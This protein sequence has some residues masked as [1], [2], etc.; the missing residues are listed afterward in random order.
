MREMVAGGIPPAT[1]CTTLISGDFNWVA[2][3]GD[4]THHGF[5]PDGPHPDEAEEERWLKLLANHGPGFEWCQ[6]NL[7]HKSGP[8][9]ARLDRVY[10]NHP[11]A[12]Q[13]DR[14][15]TC[16]T[17]EWTELSAHRA[18]TFSRSS[19]DS[20]GKAIQAGVGKDIAW[21]FHTKLRYLELTRGY[22]QVGHRQAQQ[23]QKGHEG[24]GGA[25]SEGE[26]LTPPRTGRGRR[27]EDG[28]RHEGRQGP[29][30]Q[31]P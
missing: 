7:T 24:S 2:D 6:P 12:D 17:L 27:T 20:K 21:Q 16:A 10:S 19:P 9:A 25:P 3:R 26:A 13:L 28:G 11:A 15:F 29:G 22:S 30:V 14:V 18:V 8:S 5:T 31:A 23:A 4:R 1:K